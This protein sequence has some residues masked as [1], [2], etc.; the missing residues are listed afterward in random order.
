LFSFIVGAD[1]N[2]SNKKRYGLFIIV[3]FIWN[4]N[5]Y[6]FRYFIAKVI[7][8]F[9]GLKDI[10]LEFRVSGCRSIW[11]KG[12]KFRSASTKRIDHVIKR[13]LAIKGYDYPPERFPRQL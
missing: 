2:K 13:F 1:N 12:T 4:K 11:K 10:L 8:V 6:N 7:A 5:G 3:C 9:I